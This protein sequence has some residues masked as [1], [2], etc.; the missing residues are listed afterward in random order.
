[1]GDSEDTHIFA[2]GDPVVFVDR[3]QR[4]Y[5]DTLV[6]GE[7]TNLR[8]NLIEHEQIISEPEG[9]LLIGT[10]GQ[11]F[12]VMRP[13][14][15]QYLL[16]MNRSNAII[17]PKDIGTILMWGDIFPG[18]T[19]LE[20]GVGS[21]AMTLAMLRAVGPTGKVIS[22]DLHDGP[23]GCTRTNVARYMRTPYQHVLRKVNIY[24]EILVEDHSVD[25]VV[26]DLPEPWLAL[27][28]VTEALRPGGIVSIYSPSIVQVQDTMAELTSG[29]RRYIDI[30]TFETLHR[31]WTVD[32]RRV[33]PELRMHAHSGFLT[34][35]RRVD[36]TRVIHSRERS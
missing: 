16:K 3:K 24:E 35:A 22:Y 34:F 19:V 17:Y 32:G 18:A 29:A 8:G 23:M 26:L 28:Q 2:E 15:E 7:V 21:G 4:S 13:N 27:P 31:P 25:R 11:S 9:F 5:M 1:M 6:T 12:W 30:T 10:T 20:A 33:R 36:R 14:F